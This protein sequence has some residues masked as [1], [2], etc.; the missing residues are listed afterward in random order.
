MMSQNSLGSYTGRHDIFWCLGNSIAAGT[1]GGTVVAPYVPISG[2]AFE[3]D[4]AS[5]TILEFGVGAVAPNFADNLRS[6]WSSFCERYYNDTLRFPVIVNRG[7][8][9]STLSTADNNNDWQNTGTNWVAAITALQK[10]RVLLPGAKVKAVL[11]GEI[12]INDVQ[13]LNATSGLTVAQIKTNLY[14]FIDRIIAVVGPGVPIVF[15]T[16]GRWGGGTVSA[17]LSGCR[18][19]LRSACID[20]TNVHIG[21]TLSPFVVSGYYYDGIHPGPDGNAWIGK[22]FTPNGPGLL[23]QF[24]KARYQQGRKIRFKCGLRRTKPTTYR[25]NTST[26]QW[27]DLSNE[28][29]LTMRVSTGAL[30]QRLL[31]L[32]GLQLAELRLTTIVN[33]MVLTTI[34]MTVIS[35]TFQTF[36]LQIT[37][38]RKEYR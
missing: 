16:P 21:A 23:F 35:R 25:W 10:T 19:S 27:V 8:G 31:F 28:V 33:L 32:E 1:S 12:L 15:N 26:V 6:P 36:M 29:Q 4:N 11:I 17:K 9:S 20:Y 18:N 14:D 24:M 3:Y 38:L 34:S 37:T 2:T 22:A 30:C 5:Q 13:G 7:A